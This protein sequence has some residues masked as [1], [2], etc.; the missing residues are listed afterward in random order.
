MIS[1]LALSIPCLTCYMWAVIIGL[2]YKTNTRAQNISAVL[3]LVLSLYFFTEASYLR[4][5]S[6]YTAFCVIDSLDSFV[7]LSVIPIMFLYFKS[8]TSE[9]KL[10][11]KNFLLFLPALIIGVVNIVFFIFLDFNWNRNMAISLLNRNHPSNIFYSSYCKICVVYDIIIF[12]QA[13]HLLI[14]AIIH[15]R[16]YS[17]RLRDFYSNLDDKG[18]GIHKLSLFWTLVGLPFAFVVMVTD[19]Y[20]WIERPVLTVLFFTAWTVPF[21]AF[22]FIVDKVRYS[23]ENFHEDLRLADDKE[24]LEPLLEGKML[25]AN[26]SERYEMLSQAFDV[27]IA[28]DKIF[29]NSDL[30]I[31]EV[32]RMLNTNRTYV[33][34]LIKRKYNCYFSDYINRCRVEYSKDYMK[35]SPNMKLDCVALDCGFVSSSSFCRTFKKIMGVSPMHWLKSK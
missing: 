6:S 13:V 7:T 18:I 1:V 5:Y 35:N 30:R 21:F 16:D 4:S 32:A 12:A 25:K 26:E 10:K 11:K 28:D 3:A 9:E 33:A 29:L 27:L 8:I 14:Y 22:F 19:R 15:I 17:I 31:D 24:R 20:F 2:K 23:I 34:M